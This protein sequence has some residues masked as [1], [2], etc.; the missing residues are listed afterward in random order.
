MKTKTSKKCLS[1]S[2]CGRSQFSLK[3]SQNALKVDG[4]LGLC[5]NVYEMSM[6][7]LNLVNNIGRGL[8]VALGISMFSVL[9]TETKTE[10]ILRK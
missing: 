9:N 5:M 10:N 4:N 7:L 1:Y 2:T 6:D 3:D 8:G